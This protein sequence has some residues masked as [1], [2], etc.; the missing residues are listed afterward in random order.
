MQGDLSVRV[1]NLG[2][3][4]LGEL[5][6]YFNYMIDNLN[7]LID[8]KTTMEGEIARAELMA[9][10]SQ[11]N[12]H[13][14]YNT[15]DMINW[16]AIYNNNIELENIVLALSQFYR[17]SLSNGDDVVTIES[18]A[19]H[20]E[21]YLIIQKI[22]FKEKI[23]FDIKLDSIKEYILPKITIQPLVEN[24]IIHGILEKEGSGNK[25]IIYGEKIDD[26]I[27]ITILDNGIGISKN[28]LDLLNSQQYNS[29]TGIRNILKRLRLYFGEEASLIYESTE[30][31]FSKAILN[32]PAKLKNHIS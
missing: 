23:S 26:K 30:G 10:Q 9:L 3:D 16:Q 4:E 25:V 6:L 29:G 17:Q 19:K 1:E 2:K 5:G 14:L 8:K 12:P 18:E 22:R 13:F 15:L 20:I 24:A 28:K 32:F 27:V 11:I 31:V 7:D 21:S